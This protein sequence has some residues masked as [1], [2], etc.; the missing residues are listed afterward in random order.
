MSTRGCI[1][2]GRARKFRGIYNH[3]DNYPSGIGPE[4]W[5][6]LKSYPS[7]Q[8][9]A[10]ELLQYDDWRAFINKGVCQ[11]CGHQRGQPHSFGGGIQ[12][13]WRYKDEEWIKAGLVRV[14]EKAIRTY[15]KGMDWAEERPEEV[16]RQIKADLEV[17]ANVNRTGFPDPQVLFHEHNELPR[18][19][20]HLSERSIGVSWCEW[21]YLID[22]ANERL[23][24]HCV[25]RTKGLPRV[26]ACPLDGP[27]PQWEEMTRHG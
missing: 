13:A 24:V 19:Q 20:H 9:F 4:L 18:E 14:T 16:Q 8:A 15:W 27:E 3:F 23:A 12:E 7:A 10:D 1:G 6:K 17:L 21:I 2:V 22:P 5:K 25:D 11:Y 26:A